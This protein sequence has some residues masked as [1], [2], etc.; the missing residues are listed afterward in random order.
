M[1]SASGRRPVVA[2]VLLVTAVLA[3]V[4]TAFAWPAVRSAPRDV[5][6]V[7]APPAAAAQVAER[8]DAARPG[9]FEVTGVADLNAA[10]AAVTGR[11]AYAAVV[12]GAPA[13]T[14]LTASAAS[15][16]VA[17][18][19]GQVAAALTPQAGGAPPAP[20]VEDLAPLPAADPRGAGLVSASLPLALGGVLTAAVVG[21]LPGA[22]RRVLAALL[23]AAGAA[24]AMTAVLQT[25]LGAL[26]GGFVEVAGVM[27]LALAAGATLVLGL[28]ALLGRGGTALA[29]ATLVLLGNPLSGAAGGPQVLPAGWG[30][31]GQLLPPGA[32]ASALRSVAFFDGVG[33]GAA[34][35]VLGSWLLLGLLGVGVGA[36][37]DGRR[38]P[39]TAAAPAG[40]T[41]VAAAA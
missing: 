27:A 32:A 21:R 23:A 5:P 38:R 2:A 15:P 1:P 40:R 18:L 12:L 24:A 3:V 11:E 4:V 39:T 29:A 35:A 10:R 25:W 20:P 19:V 34:L 41:P 6:L 31:L 36:A 26:P 28:T 8:L 17:Q 37:R 22:G 16:A 14:V 33:A 9:A 13:P 7:V 30:D